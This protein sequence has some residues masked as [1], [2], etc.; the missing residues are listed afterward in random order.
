MCDQP[1]RHGEEHSAWCDLCR[2]EYGYDDPSDRLDW[3]HDGERWTGPSSG[4][5]QG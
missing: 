4:Q 5:R 1:P 3:E 2:E